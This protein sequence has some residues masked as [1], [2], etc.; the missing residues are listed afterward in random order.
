[1]AFVSQYDF[2]VELKMTTR[3]LENTKMDENES[4]ADYVNR[5]R[6]KAAQMHNKLDL[7][8]QL[9]IIIKNLSSAFAPYMVLSQSSPDFETFY[10]SGL[11]VEEAL[12]DG[13]LEKKEPALKGK[14]LYPDSGKVLF[15]NSNTFH[16]GNSSNAKPLEI[17]QIADKPTRT[18]TQFSTPLSILYE[19]LLKAGLIKPLLPTPLPQKLLA[20]HDPNAFCSFHQMPGHNTNDC[21]CFR[22]AIQD[23]IDNKV[24]NAPPQSKPNSMSKCNPCINA[25]FFTRQGT[26]RA[27]QR[28]D[29]P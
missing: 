26:S 13:A 28:S 11:A 12:R 3:E 16:V 23:L 27:M 6:A 4:F 19:Q 15:G 29:L 14:G 21:I 10:D 9:R 7:K 24:I 1:M 17:N 20:Y 8:E 18:F 2:N 25:A 5:W 22:H